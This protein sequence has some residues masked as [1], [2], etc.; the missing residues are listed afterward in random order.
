[1]KIKSPELKSFSSVHNLYYLY[2]VYLFIIYHL[3]SFL[4]GPQGPSG[5]SG[6]AG[7]RGMVVSTF[8]EV[9][10][11]KQNTEKHISGFQILEIA[12][13]KIY[14]RYNTWL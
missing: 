11:T 2:E 12:S 4:K 14:Y 9:C 13:I 10:G 3:L 6:P 1:M 7:A 8:F 5:P